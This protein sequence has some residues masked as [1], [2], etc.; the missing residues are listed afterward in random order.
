MGYNKIKRF[1][2][3]LDVKMLVN[4]K[5][6]LVENLRDL[7]MVT[8]SYKTLDKSFNII[9]S[10]SYNSYKQTNEVGISFSTEVKG[11]IRGGSLK[12]LT[13]RNVKADKAFE[14]IDTFFTIVKQIDWE[15]YIN[16]E[17]LGLC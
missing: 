13:G 5:Y 12:T 15:T 7:G 2:D 11:R 1:F 17:R 9:V 10:L 16:R 8:Y 14:L 3:E 6:E 4:N